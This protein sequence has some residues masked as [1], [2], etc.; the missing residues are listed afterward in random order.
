MKRKI[1]AILIATMMVGTLSA[2]GAKEEANKDAVSNVESSSASGEVSL[3]TVDVEKYVELGEYKGLKVSVQDTV[4]TDAQVE[5][6]AYEA[7]KSAVT[8]ENGGE[9]EGVVENGD[10]VN[11]NY[12]GKKDGVA[13]EGGTAV[14]QLLTIGSGGFIPGFEEGLIGVKA[15]E[16]VDLNLSFPEDYHSADLAGQAVVFT[17]TVNFIV[18]TEMKDEVVAGFEME[19]VSTVDEFKQSARESLTKQAEEYYEKQV[20]D[21]V[22]TEFMNGCVIKDIPEGLAANYAGVVSQQIAQQAMFYGMSAEQFA[23]AA[24]QMELATL[25]EEYSMA[26][27]KQDMALQAVANKEN[28]IVEE[29]EIDDFLEKSYKEAGAKTVEEFM[30]NNSRERFRDYLLTDKVLNYLIE[31][32]EITEVATVD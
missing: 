6:S 22:L 30:G 10:T 17:V 1:V 13:F 31:N 8:L 26:G 4:V 28:I 23:Q 27:A 11:I 21:A 18:P 7:Y 14:S 9:V 19:G 25:V 5:E 16:T 24:Y 15:G 32:A 3:A 12:E 20:Q 29:Q 2:C